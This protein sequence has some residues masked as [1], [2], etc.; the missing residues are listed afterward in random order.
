MNTQ[1]DFH[2]LVVED[3]PDHR[4]LMRWS[5]ERLDG[6]AIDFADTLQAAQKRIDGQQYALIVSDA[7]L[8]DGESPDYFLAQGTQKRTPIVLITGY[9]DTERAVEC[10]RQ[11]FFDYR[12]KSEDLL[13]NLDQVVG[14]ARR[15]IEA[16]K[17]QRRA[18]RELAEHK[19]LME[20]IFEASF[21]FM[22]YKDRDSV[23]RMANPAFCRFIGRGV[24][25]VIGRTDHDLFPPA[26]ASAYVAGD[27]AVMATG[28]PE[29]GDWQVPGQAGPRW[30]QVIKT[31]VRGASGGIRGV[32]CTV[33]DIEDRKRAETAL[34]EERQ[35]YA[36]IIEGADVGTWV[37]NVV[38]GET[39]F[40]ARWA[41][42]I[43]YT[44]E[45]LEPVSIDTWM[46]YA[47]S[48]DL[49][50]SAAR[51]ADYWRGEAELYECEVRMR[52]K[53][54]HWVWVLDRGKVIQRT[55]DGEPLIM[56]GT[57]SD[58]TARKKVEAELK[59]NELRY[60][61]MVAA[62]PD[63]LFRIDGDMR[64][65]DCHAG[66]P[67]LLLAPPDQFLGR[68]LAEVLPA[69]ICAQTE[70][71]VRRTLFSG[72]PQRYGY[73]L[74]VKGRRHEFE[75]RMVTSGVNEVLAI[76]RD[77]TETRWLEAERKRLAEAVQQTSEAIAIARPDGTIEYAN[78]AF[79]TITGYEVEEII[80]HNPRFLQSGRQSD[81]IYR[82]LHGIILSCDSSWSGR[83]A[84]T[85]EDGA[86]FTVDCSVTPV[87]DETNAI[88][89]FVCL[90]R[91]VTNELKLEQ[92]L[93]QAQ[94]MEAIGTLAGGIAHDFNNILFPIIGMAEMLLDDLPEDRPQHEFAEEIFKAAR[95]A[96]DLVR[97]ILAFSRQVESRKMPL[98]MQPILKEVV[99]LCRA[100]IPAYIDMTTDIDPG[101]G[102]VAAD[103]T[104]I[105][106]VVM[107]LITNAYHATDKQGGK[108]GV[109]LERVSLDPDDLP[110]ACLQPG[111]HARIAVS[112]NGA[113]I[114]PDAQPRIFDPYYT[115]KEQGKGTGLGL[116]V[117]HGIVDEHGG[118]IQVESKAGRGTTFSV[119]LPLLEEGQKESQPREVETLAGGSETILL[120]DDEAAIVQMQ[121]K[122]L[123]RLGY[124]VVLHT[125][126]LEALK[127]F[128]QDPERFDLI[129]TDMT[130]PEMTGDRLAT[131]AMDTR[132]G[133][134][135]ILCTGYSERISPGTAKSLGIRGF[136]MKPVVKSEMAKMVR[137][138]L[139]ATASGIDGPP[140]ETETGGCPRGVFPPD[141]RP[142]MR[143][144]PIARPGD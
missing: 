33:R 14:H 80:D 60:R 88:V 24:D 105:H 95:R 96:S 32:L 93:N 137:R 140:V 116:S 18:E 58:I 4:Q 54:G 92:R 119:Y 3:D 37:W 133:M 62:L 144:Q 126:S 6:V 109:T 9:A 124:R 21:D 42:I 101:C 52:H 120:V 46:T 26:E 125:S 25:E 51:L 63:I 16:E 135:V 82:Q 59:K 85:R 71:A 83:L 76:V 15:Q 107:N 34:A 36:S 10:L 65:V 11:G 136:L 49:E 5:L 35:R 30:Q 122:M 115:T 53:D 73:A 45:E 38:T 70:Q 91:D 74:T 13:L 67:E 129:I 69:D 99:K 142:G 138:V 108:I 84:E 19:Q 50:T 143:R 66:V 55:P 31:P 29:I 78:N 72:A 1:P 27:A 94:K 57:H 131:A 111:A 87:T 128:R 68:R 100:T 39:T 97:Q 127:T 141:P 41:Q 2:V 8:P 47:H 113:G 28:R 86:P 17:K 132:P 22:V 102:K 61:A 103:P 121:Q 112:D 56:C 81:G 117:V 130:M 77:V 40:N 134:P 7:R 43:G 139:E 64:F 75:V 23:Y 104:Q 48:K 90:M 12:I 79:G 123:Q 44:L 98:R 114:A 89:N 106:Q 20:T 110:C 118:G